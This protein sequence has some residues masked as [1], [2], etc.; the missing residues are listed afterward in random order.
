MGDQSGFTVSIVGDVNGDGLDDILIGA[1]SADDDSGASYVVFG[2]GD[3]GIVE[4]PMIDNDNGFILN[5]V[6][7][8]DQSGTSVS[9]AGDV[10]GDGLDDFIIGARFA[11][12]DG[13]ATDDNRGA[14]YVVFGRCDGGTIELSEIADADNHHGFVIN[15]AGEGDQSGISVSGAGDINGDGLDDVIIGA[16]QAASVTMGVA[17]EASYVVFGKA[18]GNVV[19]LSDIENDGLGGFVIN[20]VNLGD[21]SGN[22][23]SAAGDVDGDGFDDLLIGASLADPNSNSDSGT[24]YVIFGGVGVSTLAIVGDE[25]AETLTGDSMGNQLIGGDGNDTLLG[26]GGADVLRGGRG[27]DVLALGNNLGDADFAVIDGGLG[28]DT[29]RLDSAMTLDLTNIPNNRL[30]SIEIIDLNG[31]GSRLM[32]ATDDILSI[33]GSGAE[34]ILRIDGGSSDTLDLSQAPFFDNERTED[35]NGI[36]YHIYQPVPSLGL[37]DSVRLLVAPEVMVEGATTGIDAVELSAIPI[38]VDN[39]GFLAN[40]VA[41]D[42]LSGISVSGAGDVNG[43]GFDDLLIGATAAEPNGTSSGASYVVFGRSDKSIVE[44]SE[45]VGE[46]NSN[47]FVLNGVSE[48]DRSGVS[49]SGAGDVNGDGLDDIIIGA[50]SAEPEGFSDPDNRGASY[51]VFGKTSGGNVE[52]SDIADNGND[53]GFVLN[54]AGVS[55]FSGGSVSGAGDVN[56]DGFDDLLIGAELA[57]P[58]GNNSGASYVV[59]GKSNGIEIELGNIDNDDNDN[60]FVINGVSEGVRSGASVSGAGDVNGDGLDDIIIGASYAHPNGEQSGASYVVFGKRDGSEIDLGNIANPNNNGGFVLNGALERDRSGSSVSGAGDVNGDGLDD[61]IIGAL[62]ADPNGTDSGASYV[63]FGKTDGGEIELRDIADDAGFVIN[64]VSGGDKS[65]RSVSRAGDVNGDGLE[66]IIIGAFSAEP[67]GFSDTDNRGAS[68]VVFGKRDGNA[69]ELSLIE[70]GF[71]G[72]VINGASADDQSGVSV[73]GAGDINGDGFDDLLVGA[74]GVDGSRGASY[75]IFGGQGSDLANVGDETANTLTSDSMGNQLIGGDGNDTLLGMGGAD[76]LRGGRGDDVLAISDADFAVV[77]GGS[78]NDTLRLDSPMTLDLASIPNNRLDSIEIIDL[79]GMGSTLVLATDDILSIVGSGA[80]NTLQIDGN[81]TNILDLGRTAFFDSGLE[82]IGGVD[83]RIYR[84][85]PSLELDDSVRLLVD[86]EVRVV[87]AELVTPAIELS[88]L[89]TG[90]G[91]FVFNGV[92]GDDQSGFSVSGVGDIDGDGLDDILIGAPDADNRGTSYVVF[93]KT[94]D[95]GVVVLSTIADGDNGFVL[96]GASDADRSGFSV[97]GA[98]DVNGD[99]LDDIIIGAR[100]ADPNGT[101]SGAS[102]VVFGKTG[103]GNVELGNIANTDGGTPPI[104]FVLNGVDASDLSGFSVSGAG[105]VNGDGLDDILIGARDAAPNGADSGESYVVF[106]KT[107]GGNVELSNIAS[108]DNNDGFVL[109]GVN[110]DD[111]S[112]ASVSGAGDVNGDGLDDII[113]GAYQANPNGNDSGASYVVFGKRDGSEIELGDIA[114]DNNDGFVLNG[115]T[116]DD[117]SGRSVSG[118]GDVNGDGLDDIIIG[119]HQAD[120]NGNN[121]SGASYVVF[122]KTNNDIVELSDIADGADDAGFVIKGVDVGDR[123]GYS[124]S[125]AGDINGDGLDDLIIGARDADQNGTTNSGASYLVFGKRDGNAIELSDVELGFDGFLINEVNLGDQSGHSVSGAGDVN[126]DGFDDLIVGAIGTDSNSNSNSGASYLIFGGLGVSN[127]AIVYDG[128]SDTLTG[129]STGN[130]LIGGAS[131]DTL[132][133]NGGAD[134]LRGGAGDDVLAISDIDFATID[135]GL[136][137]DTLRLDSAMNLNLSTIPNNRLD[138]I[139]IIDLNGTASTLVLA[140]DDILS[141]VG[142]SAANTLQID[143]GSTDTLDLGQ[144]VFFDSGL[145]SIGGTDYR[146][147]R[148]VPSLG[149]D[150]SVRLLIDSEVNVKNALVRVDD[151]LELSTIRMG[152]GA[153]V[154]GF[155]LNG[156]NENEQSGRS[157]SRAGDVNGDGL[158]DIIIGA[159]RAD[160]VDSDVNDRGTSYVVFGKS[161]G[162]VVELSAIADAATNNDNGFVLNGASAVDLSG[163]SVSGAGDVNG[164]GLDDIIIGARAAAPNGENSGVSYVV[165]GKTDGGIVELSMIDNDDGFVINGASIGDRSGFAVSGAGDI[166]GDGLDDILVGARL[167]DQNDVGSDRGASYV[168]FGKTDGNLVELS[169]I[170]DAAENDNAGFVLNGVAMNDRSGNSV[171]GAGDINGDGLDDIIIGAH[172]AD[173][174]NVDSNS[175]ASYVVF[176]KSDGG[177]VELSQIA[178]EDNDNGFVLNGVA[179]GDQ[180]GNSVSGAGDVNGDGLDDIIIGARNADPNGVDS[181]A[182]YVVFGKSDGGV[183]ALGEIASDSNPDGFVLNGVSEGDQSGFSVSGAGDI[184]GDGLNDIIIG[185]RDADPNGAGSGASY[186]VF[187]KRDGNAVELSSIELGFGGFVINGENEGNFSGNS[188]S[189]AGDVNGDGFDDLIVGAQRAIPNG[190]DSGTSY[191]I[192]GGQGVSV[193]ADVGGDGADT[194]TG[195]SGANQLIGGD[196]NDILIGNGGADVLR[197]GG[198]VVAGDDILAISDADF[199]VIDGGLGNDTLR[200]DAPI[201]LDLSILGNSKIRSIENIDLANDDGASTLSL[202]LSDVLAISGQTTLDNPLNISGTSGDTVNLSGAPDGGIA[203]AWSDTDDDNT[204]SYIS[205]ADSVVLANVLFDDAIMVNLV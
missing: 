171:S 19:E 158:D 3:G 200:F 137:G 118:A 65:G 28:N 64:G 62:Q 106:G 133:G 185:A 72:F 82:A 121:D 47:G 22:S 73:S 74:S 147:Y 179:M 78:G 80:E 189:G 68:Y 141:I 14:S 195:D 84:P 99:G 157:V 89:R 119:A 165:F 183:V 54:G 114:S 159:P 153:N 112:G 11:E 192:F 87:N 113:I 9:G 32:L 16:H 111:R 164:D 36:S 132:V 53:N 138:N 124:V 86:S 177:V 152:D 37:D 91:G 117:Q 48:N 34:N 96:N 4:L 2:K 194:L 46:D 103:E 63:V 140:T 184:N 93:G 160:A 166:N 71:G 196:G 20:G 155:A 108:P 190:T 172:Y 182:S 21:Q 181:G 76:V 143:G 5:G 135:G 98:G 29:L 127:S 61:I 1:P 26:M 180:S 201:N 40:G 77:D 120:S 151:A 90:D 131:D 197:G 107:S 102:Y 75:V 149:L 7:A 161:D 83:Y 139:E 109:N 56:G 174:N 169:A 35:I 10:N 59:F 51:V 162:G 193:S 23:V 100:D 43:D 67:E 95:E 38:T 41:M 27:D 105:D 199:A 148:P 15:G 122:G 94:D 191:V 8:G 58:N 31:T 168:V 202:G 50:S 186:L 13:I 101:F 142:S 79:N 128:T 204:Y 203:G 66:D 6:N 52:L 45:I 85:I 55:D 44:L 125:G 60:G 81:S 42:D 188:V 163:H 154:R 115:V 33:V 136:G 110:M 173:L 30:D 24:S 12:P 18:N 178:S 129:D 39:D 130:Q 144:T 49:V 205:A 134:V 116:M 176:G 156:A 104:G 92:S 126:G 170:A 146:I 150:D 123:S 25:N 70:L 167:A 145:E 88:A 57:N 175:G 198:G 69:V 187:G 97:S 17:L